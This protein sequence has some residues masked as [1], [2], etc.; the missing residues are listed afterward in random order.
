[1]IL[2]RTKRD[3]NVGCE[4]LSKRLPQLNDCRLHVFGHI[5]EAHGARIVKDHTNER[6]S[7]NA[8]LY[9]GHPAVTVDL[10]N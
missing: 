8:A 3:K 1:M 7:V 5:H 6:V 9:S 4:V 10:R 2:D